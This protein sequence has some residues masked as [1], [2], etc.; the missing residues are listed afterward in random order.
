MKQAA[1]ITKADIPTPEVCDSDFGAF[2]E[3]TATIEAAWPLP[4]D[5]ARALEHYPAQAAQAALLPFAAPADRP[6]PEFIRDPWA[7]VNTVAL[8][9]R[10]DDACKTAGLIDY[11][12]VAHKMGTL[13]GE[14]AT[15][16][17]KVTGSEQKPQEGCRHFLCSMG[18]GKVK[19]EADLEDAHA[20]GPLLLAAYIGGAWI[21][22]D[23]MPDRFVSVW[24]QEVEKALAD[25]ADQRGQD[26]AAQRAAD[27]EAA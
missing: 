21:D 11:W 6:Q 26:R 27:R 14:L 5:K 25:D 7:S 22:V 8:R 4:V 12:R 16:L 20:D 15:A 10:I 18:D 13:A 23:Q 1:Q 17:A 2:E 3:A 24:Q 19:V 9:N